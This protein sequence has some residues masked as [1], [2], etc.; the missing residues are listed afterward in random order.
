MNGHS[1]VTV[2]IEPDGVENGLAGCLHPS[3]QPLAPWFEGC[4][5]V[6]VL[7]ITLAGILNQKVEI[8]TDF[9]L[10]LAID[11]LLHNTC[12]QNWNIAQKDQQMRPARRETVLSPTVFWSGINTCSRHL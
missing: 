1:A 5:V 7:R 6:Q 8:I 11:L 2:V 9:G 4:K 10:S 12:H 3:K